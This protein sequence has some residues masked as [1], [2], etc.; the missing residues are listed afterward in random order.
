MA[1]ECG[2]PDSPRTG[3]IERWRTVRRELVPAGRRRPGCARRLACRISYV[4]RASLRGMARRAP[5]VPSEAERGA[6]AGPAAPRGAA[7][8]FSITKDYSAAN[9]SSCKPGDPGA[10]F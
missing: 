3:F 7:L 1:P 9:C 8:I 6:D 4:G 10:P 2:V 5:G